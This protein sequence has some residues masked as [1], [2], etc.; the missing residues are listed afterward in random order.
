VE[1]YTTIN[2]ARLLR[3]QNRGEDA[4]RVL[5]A[6]LES[7]A[8]SPHAV[9]LR[10]FSNVTCRALICRILCELDRFDEA[11]ADASMLWTDTRHGGVPATVESV[12]ALG[13]AKAGRL[14]AAAVLVGHLRQYFVGTGAP[15]SLPAD[16]IERATALAIAG[17]GESAVA[18]LT[19]EGSGLDDAAVRQLL[20]AAAEPGAPAEGAV[21]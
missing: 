1:A 11:L 19:A 9:R 18:R 8:T 14:R 17:L 21:A 15:G 20:V 4:L 12:L 7:M 10:R 3:D 2:H 13:L 16:D 5:R 6:W